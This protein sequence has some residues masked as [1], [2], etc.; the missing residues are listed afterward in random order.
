[1]AIRKPRASD[2]RVWILEGGA[3]PFALPEY[4][5]CAYMH[6]DPSWAQGDVTRE[7]CPDP[8]HYGEYVVYDEIPG[9]VENP[10]A[11]IKMRYSADLARLLELTRRRC[12]FDVLMLQ[13]RCGS[14]ED[15]AGG[16]DK[17]MVLPGARVTQ[18]AIEKFSA[19]QRADNGSTNEMVDFSSRDLYEIVRLTFSPSLAA[20]LVTTEVVGLDVGPNP[21][22]ECDDLCPDPCPVIVAVQLGSDPALPSVIYSGDG[23]ATWAVE[24]ITTMATTDVPSD[25]RLMGRY[26]VVLDNTGN[27]YHYTTLASLLAGSPVWAEQASGFIAL[28]L[29][30]EGVY[31]SGNLY[32]AANGGYVYRLRGVGSPVEVLEAGVATAQNL[33]DISAIDSTHIVAVGASNAVVSTDDGANFELVVGPT[34]GTA[35]TA[36]DMMDSRTWLASTATGLYATRNEGATWE[37]KGLPVAM[38]AIGD[39]RHTGNVVYLGGTSNALAIILRNIA[40]GTDEASAWYVLPEGAGAIPTGQRINKLALCP[41]NYN[42][43]WAAGLGTTTDGLLVKATP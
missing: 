5:D 21:A 42:L 11:G 24:D 15:F 23:G 2:S 34:V 17:I 13:G 10:T 19:L 7:E 32:I 8:S 16:W 39:I 31:I 43:V 36:V 18:W 35:L 37:Q 26:V 3:S 6:T 12:N 30:N 14:P 4:L 9:P 28:K 22:D 29:P 27:S 25:I 20:A 1:M 40:G 33:V 38:T 41:G